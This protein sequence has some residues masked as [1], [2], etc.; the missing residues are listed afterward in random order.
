[1]NHIHTVFVWLLSV[2]LVSGSLSSQVRADE[3]PD[4]VELLR[5]VAKVRNEIRSGRIEMTS[6]VTIRP[7]AQ[8]RIS[9]LVM[10]FDKNRY[11]CE[12]LKGYEEGARSHFDGE[13]VTQFD[14]DSSTTIFKADKGSR[15]YLFDPRVLGAV[16]YYDVGMTIER[17]LAYEKAKK[18]ELI[19][20]ETKDDTPTWHVRVLDEYG[21]Q[22]DSWIDARQNGRVLRNEFKL[23]Q[24]NTVTIC[25]YAEDDEKSVFP[26]SVKTSSYYDNKLGMTHS[27]M[28]EKV[29]LNVMPSL[30][31]WALAGLKMPV[32]TPVVDLRIKQRIG[33]W[34][35]NGLS[36]NLP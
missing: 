20:A 32:G 18:V 2:V 3:P 34:N 24:A 12:Y 17:Q 9:S 14:G 23:G 28:I 8:D 25:K 15:Y 7:D 35:G 27:I 29:Q 1:M 6:K 13:L 11:R 21:Q 26:N 5:G 22:L 4:P 19:G 30:D 33:Y 36:Q 16:S 10:V 31:T